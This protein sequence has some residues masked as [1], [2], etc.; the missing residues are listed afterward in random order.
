MDSYQKSKQLAEIA[1]MIYQL[2]PFVSVEQ[3]A[4][5]LVVAD[6]IVDIADSIEDTES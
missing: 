6:S 1:Q 5:L 4:S 3:S 2:L